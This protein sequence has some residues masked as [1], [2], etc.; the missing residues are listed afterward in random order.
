MVHRA[1]TPLVLDQAF[2][3]TGV[4]FSPR[5]Y[6][7]VHVGKA[8]WCVLCEYLDSDAVFTVDLKGSHD[9]VIE[10]QTLKTLVL[11]SSG[12]T[13][14]CPV[15]E[16]FS[17][18]LFSCP[19]G[20][21]R[22]LHLFRTVELTP[23]WTTITAPTCVLNTMNRLHTFY[24]LTLSWNNENRP[25]VAMKLLGC[26]VTFGGAVIPQ[27]L[28]IIIFLLNPW[29]SALCQCLFIYL[30]FVN[31]MALS[32]FDLSLIPLKSQYWSAT[33]LILLLSVQ[34]NHSV[35]VP[36]TEEDEDADLVLAWC[37]KTCRAERNW[38]AVWLLGHN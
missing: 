2:W 31:F 24:L 5:M 30:Q 3:S 25:N 29:K 1:A 33:G 22:S 32:A 4:F 14:I 38:S 18:L 23:H 27:H 16:R 20:S 6:L 34:S 12:L 13:K 9:D 36:E 21:S 11:I 7:S 17:C 37:V 8:G 10:V 26:P 19:F 28:N 35:R 15:F